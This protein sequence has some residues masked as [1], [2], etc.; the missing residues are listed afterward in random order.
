MDKSL[1][2]RIKNT[3]WANFISFAVWDDNNIDNL[4][5][6]EK[7]VN[8]LN[9]NI[10]IV[11]LNINGGVKKLQNFHLKHPGGRDSW[12]RNA[13]NKGCFRGAYMTDIIKNSKSSRQLAVDLSKENIDKNLLIFREEMFFINSKDTFIIAIGDIT[14]DI[15][16]RG[17]VE[18]NK[19]IYF[20]PHYAQWG[21]TKKYFLSSV[22][23]CETFFKATRSVT[24]RL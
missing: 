19:N 16:K 5:V 14:Y 7:N 20:I 1:F 17:F 24:D 3:R 2:Y 9:Q 8:D 6:I 12:L 4:F 15:L 11:G 22:K 21:I 13:F 10:V 18:D 23:K